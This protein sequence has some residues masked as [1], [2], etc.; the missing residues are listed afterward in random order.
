M[1]ESEQDRE[2]QAIRGKIAILAKKVKQK[3]QILTGLRKYTPKPKEIRREYPG[4]N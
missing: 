3:A 2:R 1:T 4:Q